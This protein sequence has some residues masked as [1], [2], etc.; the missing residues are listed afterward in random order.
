MFKLRNRRAVLPILM[1]LLWGCFATRALATGINVYFID[2][3]IQDKDGN[4]LTPGNYHTPPTWTSRLEFFQGVNP[5]DPTA[6]PTQV[7]PGAI[8]LS[9]AP[10][11]P[12][13]Y[14]YA[15]G[16]LDGNNGGLYIRVWKDAPSGTRQHNFY[17][18]VS[19]PIASG[20]E[21]CKD[22]QFGQNPV[23][24]KT[25]HL[26]DVP[27]TPAI[28]T[29]QESLVR[30]GNSFEVSLVVPVAYNNNPSGGGIVEVQTYGLHIVYPDGSAED[31]S[32][33]SSAFSLTGPK[34]VTGTYKFTPNVTNWYGPKSGAE[35]PY[36]TLG[37]A[38]V[39]GSMAITLTKETDGLGVNSI[40]IPFAT[41]FGLYQED[42]VT[43]LNPSVQSL[44]D[45]ISGVNSSGSAKVTAAGYWG[46]DMKM[47][48]ITY[49]ASGQ[50]VY[51]CP[52]DFDPA[53]LTLTPGRG[54]YLSVD[55]TL[56]V[57]LKK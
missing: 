1:I 14:K 6:S 11:P 40:G 50:A 35:L 38:A 33:A 21:T 30:S 20:A 7:D 19:N 2:N 48:G 12:Y 25:D 47:Y 34:V 23:T 53:S 8:S 36:S 4:A 16:G 46:E 37:V 10:P 49:D 17:G 22:F 54:Y 26:A 9:T 3:S 24:I 44:A 18:I 32:Q 31:K 13:K 27:Y 43:A 29:I 55:K 39:G 28:G 41:P 5:T 42:G 57:V 15:M 56:K 52:P 45:L 51:K